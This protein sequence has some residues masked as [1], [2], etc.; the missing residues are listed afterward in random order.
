M[1]RVHE[2]DLDYDVLLDAGGEVER[3]IDR[4]DRRGAGDANLRAMTLRGH[5]PS[6]S[7]RTSQVGITTSGNGYGAACMIGICLEIPVYAALPATQYA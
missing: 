7:K 5:T 3:L 2:S 6:L 4:V 1:L